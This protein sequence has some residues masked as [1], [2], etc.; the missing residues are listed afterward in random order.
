MTA[1]TPNFAWPYPVR[2][3]PADMSHNLEQ[4][5]LAVE[6]SLQAIETEITAQRTRWNNRHVYFARRVAALS[7]ANSAWTP[8]PMDTVEVNTLGSPRPAGYYLV[9]G[10]A[11]WATVG[12]EPGERIAGIF[13]AGNSIGQSGSP[14]PLASQ[15]HPIVHNTPARIVFLNPADTIDLRVWQ[16]SGAPLALN[17]A[18]AY[19][20]HLTILHCWGSWT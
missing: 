2:G 1:T 11:S 16:S 15:V 5:A 7:T 9:A 3:D 19:Q 6:A 4:L 20:A 13:H 14:A 17:V 12:G 10:G 8:I 18:A